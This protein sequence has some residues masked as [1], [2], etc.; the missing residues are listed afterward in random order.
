MVHSIH[1][2][3]VLDYFSVDRHGLT[4]DGVNRR[5]RQNWRSAQR[6]VWREGID[7]NRQLARD[8]GIF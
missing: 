3:L 8:A 1:L 5:D 2:L 4:R 7:T 6:L